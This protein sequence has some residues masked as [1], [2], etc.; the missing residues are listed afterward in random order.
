LLR[1]P[2]VREFQVRQTEHGADVLAVIDGDLD[3]A[4]LA[5]EAEGGLRQAGLSA[6]LVAIRPVAALD[7]DPLTGKLRR[8]VPLGTRPPQP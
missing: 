6:P 4:A 7:R 5:A 8:F 3:L 1:A 2:N